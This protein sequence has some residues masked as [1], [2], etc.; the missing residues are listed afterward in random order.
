LQIDLRDLRTIEAIH[1]EGGLARAAAALGTTQ[2]ALSHRLRAIEAETRT[3]IVV[4]ATKPLRLSAAGLRLLACA[5]EVLPRIDALAGEFAELAGG[6]AGRLHLAVECHA[7]FDW[8]LPVLNRY[9]IA[10]PQVDLDLRLGLAFEAL[11][12]LRREE[13]DLVLSSDPA[14]GPDL[15]WT[16]LFDYE[17]VL[18]LA[19]T[20]PL[21]SAR[22]VTAADLEPE[23]LLTYPVERDRLDVF[24]ELLG[25]AGVEPAAIR[26]VELTPMILLL[27]AAGRGVA[28]LPN[29]VAA[30]APEALGLV[31]RPLERDGRR[32]ARRLFAAT[33]PG[34]ATKPYV[35]HLVRLARQEAV[36]LLRG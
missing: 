21:A 2:S 36:R 11:P 13:V 15:A 18:V 8:L 25:P 6:R 19:T 35:A 4:R 34:G 12:A 32:V 3:P 23:T 20:H 29:W 1:E 9:R 16:P 27:A 30:G 5:R 22:A 24:V 31:A 17:P 28:V 14:E 7:C 10:W 33:R 26:R